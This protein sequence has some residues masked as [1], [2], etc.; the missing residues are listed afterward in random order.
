MPCF[1]EDDLIVM[2]QHFELAGKGHYSGGHGRSGK[3]LTQVACNELIIGTNDIVISVYGDEYKEQVGILTDKFRTSDRKSFYFE[4]PEHIN[5]KTKGKIAEYTLR[6]NAKL[7][8]SLR[9]DQ[10]YF[11]NRYVMPDGD[12][13]LITYYDIEE[14]LKPKM[15]AEYINPYFYTPKYEPVIEL[16]PVPDI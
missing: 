2:I 16:D 14:V 7:N 10:K 6:F 4:E 9:N 11:S 5:D 13:S 3:F 8:C 15:Q 12:L 1:Q